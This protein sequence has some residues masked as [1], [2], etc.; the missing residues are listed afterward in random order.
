MHSRGVLLDY[1]TGR[2]LFLLVSVLWIPFAPGLEKRHLLQLQRRCPRVL[3]C[4]HDGER[5]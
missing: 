3:L 1:I 5:V 2:T 4:G